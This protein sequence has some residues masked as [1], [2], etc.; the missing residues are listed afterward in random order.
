MIYVSFLLKSAQDLEEIVRMWM[1]LR[2]ELGKRLRSVIWTKNLLFFP[3]SLLFL[4]PKQEP[5][6]ILVSQLEW[7][8]SALSIYS[9]LDFPRN[10]ALLY[11]LLTPIKDICQKILQDYAFTIFSLSFLLM[12]P[13][14]YANIFSIQISKAK[15]YLLIYRIICLYLW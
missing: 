6:L 13:K 3:A 5:E 4:Y 2:E 12:F 7:F 14:C 9:G 11:P 15:S 10:S 8:H 1:N